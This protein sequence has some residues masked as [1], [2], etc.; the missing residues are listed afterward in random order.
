MSEHPWTQSTLTE[1]QREARQDEGESQVEIDSE[2]EEE[3]DSRMDD[4]VSLEM[5]HMGI[6][7]DI[8]SLVDH[9][10]RLKI[11]GIP[12]HAMVWLVGDPNIIGCSVRVRWVTPISNVKIAAPK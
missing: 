2:D 1:H 6:S 4:L 8:D 9:L 3:Y 12:G 5:E 11:N 10:Q 7:R